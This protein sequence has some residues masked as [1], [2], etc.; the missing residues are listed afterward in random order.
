M[1]MVI[2][3]VTTNAM[4]VIQTVYTATIR[5]MQSQAIFDAR[6]T[7][8]RSLN[9]LGC[10]LDLLIACELVFDA[11]ERKQRFEF[12]VNLDHLSHPIVMG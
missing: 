5:A 1:P 12:V 4:G 7:P 2:G 8:W 10:Q 6:R 9:S 3:L 11:I